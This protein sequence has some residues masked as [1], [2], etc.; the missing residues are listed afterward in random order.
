MPLLKASPND[1]TIGSPR[2]ISDFHNMTHES[3]TFRGSHLDTI[4]STDPFLLLFDTRAATAQNLVVHLKELHFWCVG[5]YWDIEIMG[6]G[7]LNAVNATVY[8]T[9]CKNDRAA[10]AVVPYT[11]VRLPVGFAGCGHSL[12]GRFMVGNAAGVGT[13]Y[14]YRE[15][16]PDSEFVLHEAIDN[17]G[18]VQDGTLV[19]ANNFTGG[20]A[21]MCVQWEF[22]EIPA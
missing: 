14:S 6:L 4:A 16:D 22:I 5:H 20:N 18:S 2:A 17:A 3:M 7:N 21:M 19:R 11:I 10:V 12:T 9:R 8:T 1:R 15:N 13:S